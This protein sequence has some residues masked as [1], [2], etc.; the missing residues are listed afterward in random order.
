MYGGKNMQTKSL[1]KKGLAVGIIVLLGVN[2]AP[3]TSGSLLEKT[4]V[5]GK[6]NPVSLLDSRDINITF[7]GTM[8]EN[9]WY[10]SPVEIIIVFENDSYVAYFYYKIDNGNLT[11]YTPPVDD[12][13][14]NE[15][16]IHCFYGYFTDSQGNIEEV[17][18]PFNFKIDQTP[19]TIIDFTF[20]RVGFF[21]CIF[22]TSIFDNTSGI[23]HV[24]F[25]LDD[26]FIGN[27][28]ALPYFVY[29]RHSLFLYRLKGL[30][31]YHTFRIVP[32]CIVYDNAGNYCISQS[33]VIR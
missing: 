10:V 4:N 32:Q 9:G 6:L 18:G 33:I 22:N 15:D 30:I 29:W 11:E 23:N 17:I 7:N 25:W 5:K 16:G 12:I 24:E 13:W 26:Q 28:S 19:P 14:V 8:G 31:L 20:A 3:L 1:L 27:C 21:K 2:I